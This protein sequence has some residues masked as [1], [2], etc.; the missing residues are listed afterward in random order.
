MASYT[1]N[2]SATDTKAMEFVT[3]DTE[4]WVTNLTE[5]RA[6]KAKDQIISLLLQHCNANDI[7]MATGESAQIDQAFELKVVEPA[8]DDR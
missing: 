4:E 3:A 8:A 1:V 7:A 6:R 2:L 5:N